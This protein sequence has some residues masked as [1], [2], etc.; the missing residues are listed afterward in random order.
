MNKIT[1]GVLLA[2]SFSGYAATEQ[3]TS[4]LIALK[5]KVTSTFPEGQIHLT[6]IKMSL[7]TAL[8]QRVSPPL[9]RH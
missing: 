4:T 8:A 7:Y 1:L 5:S 3:V 9:K 6:Y 2:L